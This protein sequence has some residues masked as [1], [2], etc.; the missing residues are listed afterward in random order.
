MTNILAYTERTRYGFEYR[1]Q[2]IETDLMKGVTAGQLMD[3]LMIK[4]SLAD[5]AGE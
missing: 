5:A 1:G 3:H 4:I 2:Q